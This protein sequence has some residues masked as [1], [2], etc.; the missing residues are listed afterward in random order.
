M[1]FNLTAKNP[2]PVEGMY[3]YMPNIPQAHNVIF[4]GDEGATIQ[5][6]AVV[7]LDVASTNTV[8][9]V[10]KAAGATDKPYGVVVRSVVKDIYN[11]GDRVGVA[12]SGSSLFMV[13]G[14]AIAVGDELEFDP[15]TRKVVKGATA[16]NSLIGVA[17]TAAGADGDFVQ[18]KLNFN[19]GAVA[20]A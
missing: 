5:A 6:G 10:V 7:T 16:N 1:A 3:A 19:L 12:E 17:E 2:A 15:A 11:V 9:P 4:T 8:A 18:V 13:A 20:A 14:A